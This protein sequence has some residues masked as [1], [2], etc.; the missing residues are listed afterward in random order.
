MGNPRREDS[1]LGGPT[2]PSTNDLRTCRVARSRSVSPHLS[3]K[4]S[5]RLIPITAA[6][7]KAVRTGSIPSSCFRMAAISA[8]FQNLRLYSP[9]PYLPDV[10]NGIDWVQFITHGVS[11]RCPENLSDLCLTPVGQRKSF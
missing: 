9:F 5:P 1:V 3:P 4:I 6:M 10:G 11:E 2:T 7:R 8:G